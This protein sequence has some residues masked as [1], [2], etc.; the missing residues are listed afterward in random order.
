MVVYSVELTVSRAVQYHPLHHC[1]QGQHPDNSTLHTSHGCCARGNCTV[2]LLS[3]HPKPWNRDKN[4]SW[5][6]KTKIWRKLPLPWP[7]HYCEACEYNK[8]LKFVYHGLHWV[9]ERSGSGRRG[10][11]FSTC[12]TTLSLNSFFTPGGN[13]I[14]NCFPWY[15][16]HTKYLG[17]RTLFPTLKPR[18]FRTCAVPSYDEDS[19]NSDWCGL[20]LKH[21][22]RPEWPGSCRKE[23]VRGAER[24]LGPDEWPDCKQ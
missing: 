17:Q 12:T 11:S 3:L 21:V 18:C 1:K 13:F 23:S 22:T 2:V 7:I 9:G 16:T 6:T 15:M 10:K 5:S 20:Q 14:R 4:G 19:S 8:S 24:G